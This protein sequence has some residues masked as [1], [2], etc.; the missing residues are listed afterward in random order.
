MRHAGVLPDL[1]IL[2]G[3]A[4]GSS[5]IGDRPVFPFRP[6]ADGALAIG[7]GQAM[8]LI[9]YLTPRIEF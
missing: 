8:K 4:D 1:H 6:C 3:L 9:P 5:T 2:Y 7:A